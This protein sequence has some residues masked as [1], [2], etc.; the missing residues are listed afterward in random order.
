MLK[1]HPIHCSSSTIALL[2]L[3][4]LFSL[5]SPGQARQLNWIG[6]W[7]GAGKRQHLVEEIKREYEFLYP[8]VRVNLTYSE[9]LDTPESSYK[10]KA[11]H[12]IV[13]MIR[14]GTVNWDVIYLDGTV[15]H[16]VS[17]A[18]KD[19]NW[20]K[21]HL[22]DFS[23]IPG[24]S[25]TQKSFINTDPWYKKQ[26]GG[27]LVGPMVEGFIL[28][29]WYNPYVAHKIGIKIKERNMSI[30]D[31]ISYAQKTSS[32]NKQH[33]T[34]IPF[35][36]LTS[37]NR[38]SCLFEYLFK[39]QFTDAEF[40]VKEKFDAT[41][42]QPFLN[43]LRI[44]ER[45]STYQPFFN[46]N[47]QELSWKEWETDFLNDDGLF[48]IAG[49]FMYSHFRGN[50]P[51]KAKKVIPIEFPHIH[52][53]NG[54]VGDYVSTFAVMKNSPHRQEA[55]DLLMLWAEP[56]IA[57]EWTEYTMNP[58]GLRGS[59][60]DPVTASLDKADKYGSF[61]QDMTERY[62]QLPMR[63]LRVPTYVFGIDCPV[64]ETEFHEN[65]VYILEGELSA[66]EY[67]D[68]LYQLFQ[69]KREKRIQ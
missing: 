19:P 48:I 63:D 5:S 69:K 62:G 58:T 13:Q 7:K 33:R 57:E 26:T 38:I 10:K 46:K 55:I 3:F 9:D 1:T 8:D 23:T 39:S 36:K 21:K 16:N 41:K 14:S 64:N 6:H 67:Y 34:A 25:A 43:T 60:S 22:V 28:C 27:I 24:F 53:P 65:L 15:Y 54:L 2:L 40:A 52:Q 30:E 59:I 44:F 29:L 11:A 49:T 56:K 20:G 35:I 17:E 32:Y 51:E 50:N 37:W 18:L 61:L 31:F 66:R 45:L 42:L 68:E 12:T 4:I 47:W